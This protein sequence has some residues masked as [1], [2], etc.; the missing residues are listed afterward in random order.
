MK[1]TS[2]AK[3]DRQY[4]NHELLERSV[5]KDPFRLFHVWFAQAAQARLLDP[6][7][8]ALSTIGPKGEL[9]SRMVLLKGL[10][11]KGFVFFTNY[12][13]R[14][15]KDLAR[16]PQASLLFYWAPLGKQVRVEGSVRRITAKESDDYF[17]TRPRGSQM[18]AWASHQSQV[19]PNRTTLERRM[20]ELERRYAGQTV[21]RPPH[22]GGY[23]VIPRVVE[24]WSGRRNRLHDRL[25]YRKKGPGSWKME[26][27]AP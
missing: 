25:R 20:R 11:A 27:L 24:F 8:M 26:R 14:K 3:L 16:H 21:P 19:I 1:K 9:S 18:A 13:S 2:I 6:H 23:R 4:P 12:L 5:P 10:D 15:G 22:W 17:K 7:A